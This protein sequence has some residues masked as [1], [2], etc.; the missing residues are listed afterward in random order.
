[1]T[2]ASGAIADGIAV[3]I[4]AAFASSAVP[5]TGAALDLKLG[6]RDYKYVNFDSVCYLNVVGLA[7]YLYKWLVDTVVLS[8]HDVR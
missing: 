7:N 1:M 4:F 3:A 8:D 2:G 6:V 5:S